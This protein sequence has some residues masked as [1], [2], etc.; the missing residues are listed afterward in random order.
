[1]TGNAA[2][3][4]LGAMRRAGSLCGMAVGATGSGDSVTR[5]MNDVARSV[6][7]SLEKLIVDELREKGR[8]PAKRAIDAFL[9]RI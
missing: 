2:A 4:L 5:F 1:V 9:K 7:S 6:A 3:L 8:C